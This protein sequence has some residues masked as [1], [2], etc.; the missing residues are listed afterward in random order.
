MDLIPFGIY[1]AINWLYNPYI[2]LSGPM[3]Q[4]EETL[5]WTYIYLP[6]RMTYKKH[7]YESNIDAIHHGQ[8]V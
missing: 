1:D 5:E 4:Q 8:W 2:L 7:G 6:V 3:I